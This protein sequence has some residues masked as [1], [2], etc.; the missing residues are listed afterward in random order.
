MFIGDQPCGVAVLWAHEAQEPGRGL[1]VAEDVLDP[2]ASA[3]P[4]DLA[5]LRAARVQHPVLAAHVLRLLTLRVGTAA[6]APRAVAH[7]VAV[8]GDALAV[9]DQLA[10]DVTELVEVGVVHRRRLAGREAVRRMHAA[11]LELDGEVGVRRRD[12]ATW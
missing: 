6:R 11:M 8:D 5:P 9:Q 10:R 2:A 1:G 3:L 7:R 12:S 4:F